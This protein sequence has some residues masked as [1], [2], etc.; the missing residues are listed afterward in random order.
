MRK[1]ASAARRPDQPPHHP[2]GRQVHLAPLMSLP[3]ADADLCFARAVAH[4]QSLGPASSAPRLL[5][6]SP[7][8]SEVT[9]NVA[10]EA[11][12]SP[13]LSESGHSRLG[14]A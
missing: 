6:A 10:A 11:T 4:D 14:N 3:P 7:A 13:S 1:R 12:G 8:G 9:S 2:L 5:P